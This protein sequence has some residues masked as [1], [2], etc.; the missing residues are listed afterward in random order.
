MKTINTIL[1]EKDSKLIEE[2]ILKYGTI[3]STKE[4]LSVFEKKYS[5]ASAHNRIQKLHSF[6][7]FLR[8]KK[9]LYLI[10]DNISSRYFNNKSLFLIAKAINKN[11]YISLHSALNCHQMF[12]QYSKTVA[13]VNCDIS[14]SYNFAN[15]V[16]RF[17]KISKKYYFGFSQAR[18]EGKLINIASKEKALI[19]FLYLNSSFSSISLVYEK[20][21][22]HKNI[23][24]FKLLQT[25][26]SKF[27]TSV[28][29]KLGFLLDQLEIDSNY[30]FKRVKKEKSYSKLTQDSN[31]FN[32][33]WR[34]Y[35]DDRVFK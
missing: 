17:I 28:Q 14:K 8:I 3:V 4:L 15:N 31:I 7:W 11:S 26:A 20:L 30:L 34:L 13:V 22:N 1:S 5:K 9:G 27:G 6:G 19:D 24:D 10:V 2:I 16:I 23:I 35:Y 32:A 21:E 29:R 33:K 12:D 18:Y 25:T